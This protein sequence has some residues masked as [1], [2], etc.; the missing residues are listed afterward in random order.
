M[1]RPGPRHRD[2]EADGIDLDLIQAQPPG[3]TS[4]VVPENSF[5]PQ[6][7]SSAGHSASHQKTISRSP[8]AKSQGVGEMWVD[9]KQ[10]GSSLQETRCTIISGKICHVA[11]DQ[12]IPDELLEIGDDNRELPCGSC[13]SLVKVQVRSCVQQ[14]IGYQMAP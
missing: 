10:G 12:I 7:M 11:V 2:W 6:D 14:V 13:R 3:F 8:R 1:G 4:G 5:T 9:E